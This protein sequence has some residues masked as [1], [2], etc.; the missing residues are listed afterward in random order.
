MA[1]PL[2]WIHLMGGEAARLRPECGLGRQWIH[3]INVLASLVKFLGLLGNI[4]Y[5]SVLH[6]GVLL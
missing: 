3:L 5:S 4:F 6:T 2:F 1:L